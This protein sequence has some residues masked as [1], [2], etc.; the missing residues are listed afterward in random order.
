MKTKK[1]HFL[2]SILISIIYFFFVH[3]F[4]QVKWYGSDDLFYELF[5][6]NFG[7]FKLY[8]SDF[9]P[10]YN[11]SYL[12]Q[13]FFNSIHY[14]G[15][16]SP[17]ISFYNLTIQVLTF[18][19]FLSIVFYSFT[20]FSSKTARVTIIF[21]SCIGFLIPI[22][23]INFTTVTIIGSFIIFCLASQFSR[24]ESSSPKKQ[25]FLI[26]LIIAF[27][28]CFFTLRTK[29]YLLSV[30]L[31]LVTLFISNIKKVSIKKI[32]KPK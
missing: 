15:Q 23:K 17:S 28:T 5:N 16:L 8:D 9:F 27:S 10:I 29:S 31:V 20:N 6:G 14:F 18:F 11:I 32:L 30:A 25:Y 2:Q 26:L 7:G 1:S 4:Y 3:Y 24:L 22:T 21:F 13:L 19:S 12:E